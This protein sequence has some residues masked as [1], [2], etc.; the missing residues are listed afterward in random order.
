[1]VS[2]VRPMETGIKNWH[3]A[4]M[5]GDMLKIIR[6]LLDEPN[7]DH[8]PVAPYLVTDS[9]MAMMKLFDHDNMPG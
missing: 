6:G 4:R 3:F 2:F 8:S 5:Q 1:V 7:M 9:N